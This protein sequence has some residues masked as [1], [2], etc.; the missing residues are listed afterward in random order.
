[1]I[2]SLP[3]ATDGVTQIPL[4]LQYET[5]QSEL[6]GL[7]DK[8]NWE[9]LLRAAE[10]RFQGALLWLD[11]NRF[12]AEALTG[13]GDSFQDA[14]DAVC[15]ETA[16]LVHRIPGIESLAFLDGT[17]FCDG[18]TQQWL[19]SIRL[20]RGSGMDA[21]VLAAGAGQDGHMAEMIQ[22]A[23]ALAKKKE[24]GRALSILQEELR[25]SFSKQEQLLWRLG[26]SQILLSANK[27]Q[28]ALPQL[29]S[30]LQ[31]IDAYSLEEWDP[32]LALKGLKVVWQ[33]FS[34]LTDESIKS[35]AKDV[36]NRIAKLDPAEALMF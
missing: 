16:Y 5:V 21:P 9:A 1:M 35:Q 24:V 8:G 27:P 28:L 17:P 34:A 33:G 20:G 30:I 3:P 19:K 29:E 12:S 26:L 2:Q 10:E 6:K 31:D 23:Q 36:L 7:K 4:P 13:L 18:E 11:L 15:R 25:S 32:N 14:H 22:Q